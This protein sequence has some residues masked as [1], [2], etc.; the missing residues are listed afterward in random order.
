MYYYFKYKLITNFLAFLDFKSFNEELM[1]DLNIFILIFLY[2]YFSN[3]H[4]IFV[5]LE[6][7]FLLL[8]FKSLTKNLFSL[9]FFVLALFFPIF[10]FLL[11]IDQKFYLLNFYYPDFKLITHFFIPWLSLL[12]V[13]IRVI[14]FIFYIFIHKLFGILKNNLNFNSEIINF[15]NFIFTLVHLL[16]KWLNIN[17]YFIRDWIIHLSHL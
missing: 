12:A 16:M 9:F 5:I 1:L 14:L 17:D 7:Y 6:N 11:K 10:S 13:V 8:N 3:F 4:L 2:C 15:K